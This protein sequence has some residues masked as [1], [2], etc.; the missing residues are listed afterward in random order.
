MYSES[1]GYPLKL[2]MDGQN[3]YAAPVPNFVNISKLVGQ[4]SWDHNL[5]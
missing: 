5:L 2:I 3:F 4:D 1:W